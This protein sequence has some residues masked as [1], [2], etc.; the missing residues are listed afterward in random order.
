MST[1]TPTTGVIASL[2]PRRRCTDD[3]RIRAAGG[4]RWMIPCRADDGLLV[5]R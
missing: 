5:K 2:S 1:I 3:R 4:G